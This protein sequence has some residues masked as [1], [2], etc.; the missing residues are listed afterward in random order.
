MQTK[1]RL[2]YYRVR[3]DEQIGVKAEIIQGDVLE[4]VYLNFCPLDTYEVN[5]MAPPHEPIAVPAQTETFL[6]P[7]MET[8]V[9]MFENHEMYF[10]A[11][12]VEIY[13]IDVLTM[14]IHNLAKK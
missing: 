13:Y 11:S 5:T 8:A 4:S 10:H 1:V 2:T 6:L 12:G 3:G 9:N 7:D 14:E